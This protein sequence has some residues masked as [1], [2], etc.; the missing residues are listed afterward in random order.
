MKNIWLTKRRERM[1]HPQAAIDLMT[2]NQKSISSIFN[3]EDFSP[4]VQKIYEEFLGFKMVS[5]QPMIAPASL[6]KYLKYERKDDEV[7]LV[8]DEEPLAAKSRK[9][10]TELGL[11]LDETAKSIRE[12]ITREIAT[13]LTNNAGTVSVWD[14]SSDFGDTLKEQYESLYIKIFEISGVIHRKTLRGRANWLYMNEKTAEP[15]I[16][17]CFGPPRPSKG[18]YQHGVINGAWRLIIDTEYPDNQ[19]LMGHKGDSY[20]DA[21]Y[22]YCPYFLTTQNK[23]LDG[24][25]LPKS[26]SYINKYGKKL[27]KEGAKQYA[28]LTILPA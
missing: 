10:H 2:E 8:V 23:I 21:G 25:L 16:T 18:V 27:M 15:F 24:E 22:F 14:R 5:V 13:D 19:I 1:N 20:M 11:N 7:N 26:M 6:I 28:K 12:E 4:L 9:L 17:C 3:T